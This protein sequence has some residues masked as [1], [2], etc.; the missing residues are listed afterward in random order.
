MTDVW[1]GSKF[2]SDY[3]TVNFLPRILFKN[4]FSWE[5]NK[6]DDMS[7]E[8]VKSVPL[9]KIFICKNINFG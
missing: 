4:C 9:V 5:F 8:F 2:A 3:N 7:D 1:K 6:K